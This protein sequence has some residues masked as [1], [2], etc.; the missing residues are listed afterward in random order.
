LTESVGR[1]PL[2]ERGAGLGIDETI[3][4]EGPDLGFGRLA[5]RGRIS[6]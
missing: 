6:A 3:A 1:Q 2:D 5:S 4:I